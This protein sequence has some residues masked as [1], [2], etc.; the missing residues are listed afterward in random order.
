M[1]ATRARS[2]ASA[3]IGVLFAALAAFMPGG[4][5]AAEPLR[6]VV[7]L[8]TSQGCAAC[9][10]ADPVIGDLSRQP[11]ILALTLP[12]TY[13][14]YLGWKDTLAQRPFGERQHAYSGVQGARQVYTPQAVVNG[15]ASTVGSDRAALETLLRESSG[16]GGLP[17]P[18][19]GEERGRPHRDRHRRRAESES[20]SQGRSLAGSGA[21]QPPGRDRRRREP[22][23]VRPPT[24]TSCAAFSAS[25][26]GPDRRCGSRCRARQ[27]ASRR[28]MPGS[29]WFRATLG[30]RPGPIL[31][32]AKGPGL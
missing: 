5:A 6:A 23:A 14:D 7:E 30:G 1:T 28:P 21:A 25:V 32:A 19:R 26:P 24:S 13:W 22:R 20:G 12:V 27:P 9:R 11:G 3:P 29:W 2:H 31:G 8:F 16:R 17:V 4:G 10:S 18:V 15:T